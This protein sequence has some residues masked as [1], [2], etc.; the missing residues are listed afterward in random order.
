MIS[1]LPASRPGCPSS[2]LSEANPS[3]SAT[4]FQSSVGYGASGCSSAMWAPAVASTS[5]A[6]RNAALTTGSTGAQPRSSD[7]ATR[8]DDQSGSASGVS[9]PGGTGQVSGS[10][11]AG[12]A[13]T[14]RASA[15]SR[16]VRVSG[17][18]TDKVGQPRKPG[19]LGT[20]PKVGLWPT[21]PQNAA[22]I[23]ID[24]P[25][26]VPRAI[27][28]APYATEAPAPPLEPP[29]VRSSDQGLRVRP[30]TTLSV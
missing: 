3:G 30:H 28:V 15:A 17:P 9:G 22:G 7:T 12:P 14:D 27:V 24:P 1:R 18:S 10:A 16:T 11:R 23:R 25:P 21:T 8:S 4:S 29:G 13:M 26:S 5:T 19:I 6:D 2:E 20:R